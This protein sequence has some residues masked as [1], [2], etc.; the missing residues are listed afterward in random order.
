MLQ[1]NQKN[2]VFLSNYNS[3]PGSSSGAVLLKRG[4]KLI[5][6]HK[7]G[8]KNKKIK[9]NYIL[10]LN[11]I[12]KDLNLNKNTFYKLKFQGSKIKKLNIIIIFYLIYYFYHLLLPFYIKEKKNE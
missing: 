3:T 4:Y 9:F 11:V 5:G 10:P 2:E 6:M 1:Y 8:Y 12:L 7:G